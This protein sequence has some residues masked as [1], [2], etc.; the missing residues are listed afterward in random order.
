MLNYINF[1]LTYIKIYKINNMPR[2]NKIIFEPTSGGASDRVAPNHDTNNPNGPY[3]GGSLYSA[4]KESHSEM[5]KAQQIGLDNDVVK[6][7][8]ANFKNPRTD[9][10]WK[11][12]QA[13]ELKRKKTADIIHKLLKPA[14]WSVF[15]Y[16][17]DGN[18]L[19]NAK[20]AYNEVFFYF[21]IYIFIF[22]I[23]FA[24]G[25][26]MMLYYMV[27]GDK[28]PDDVTIWKAVSGGICFYIIVN[29]IF[30]HCRLKKQN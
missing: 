15:E 16:E 17:K 8:D 11:I 7:D 29:F 25:V 9:R 3:A 21:R 24:I 10:E 19:T 5:K 27:S 12:K 6:T 2:I 26:S 1:I 23:F 14:I 30:F 22:S 4:M 20:N 13:F 18:A 28:I